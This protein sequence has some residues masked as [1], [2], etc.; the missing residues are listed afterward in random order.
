MTACPNQPKAQAHDL[1]RFR[2]MVERIA[3]KLARRLPAHLSVEDLTG[4]GWVG[5]LEAFERT[6]ADMP[7]EELAAFVS[8]RVRGAML[9]HV[10]SIDP[11]GRE[12]RNASRRLARAEQNAAPTAVHRDTIR[13]LREERRTRL[14]SF[15]DHAPGSASSEASAE[16]RI[17]GARLDEALARLP[18]RLQQIITLRYRDDWDHCEIASHLG[19]TPSRISQLHGEAMK[20]L[21]AAIE[22]EEPV[23]MGNAA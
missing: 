20:R 10:R 8:C 7:Q 15:D 11:V 18:A 23:S 3:R 21:R 16:E 2:P 22:T 17:L 12:I 9:D 14:V 13:R 5:L 4:F 6:R 19:V 1:E